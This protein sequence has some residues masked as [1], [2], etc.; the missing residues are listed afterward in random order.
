LVRVIR[1]GKLCHVHREQSAFGVKVRCVK[2]RRSDATTTEADKRRISLSK[3]VSDTRYVYNPL[4][5]SVAMRSMLVSQS[6]TPNSP[7]T[8]VGVEFSSNSP[9]PRLRAEI[10]LPKLEGSIHVFHYAAFDTKVVIEI[11]PKPKPPD[12]PLRG[13]AQSGALHLTQS[14]D[15]EK[16]IGV[17]MIAVS[18]G[19]VVGSLVEDLF[20]AG[21]GVADDPATL[22]VAGALLVEGLATL[23]MSSRVM[24]PQAKFPAHVHATTTIVVAG[25]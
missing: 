4:E 14:P 18:I 16:L 15:L 24:L 23:G 5:K 12:P 8:A 22:S 25:R 19:I 9:M 1:Q 17:G 2:S 10:R 20:T 11:T 13:S 3:L 6:R 7:A 21:A